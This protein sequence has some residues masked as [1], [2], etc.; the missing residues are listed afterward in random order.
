MRRK[1]CPPREI[2]NKKTPADCLPYKAAD[3]RKLCEDAG[4]DILKRSRRIRPAA[5][6]EGIIRIISRY[7]EAVLRDGT[8]ED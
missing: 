4:N 6:V 3:G 1:S 7:K 8:A 2:I 5:G